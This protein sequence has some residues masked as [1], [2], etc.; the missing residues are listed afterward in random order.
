LHFD[1]LLTVG[2]RAA[3]IAEG[4]RQAGYP[5]AKIKCFDQ[6]AD[7]G[8]F[9]RAELKPEAVVLFKGSRGMVLEKAIAEFGH[10]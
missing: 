8:K 4:A 10:E 1:L 3:D 9:L 7:A 2:Q 5:A 6:A